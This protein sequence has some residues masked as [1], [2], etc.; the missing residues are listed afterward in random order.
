MLEINSLE[1]NDCCGSSPHEAGE[2]R[3]MPLAGDGNLILCRRCWTRELNWRRD[4][5]R[6]LS[7]EAAY[8]LPAWDH[9]KVYGA[10]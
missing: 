2:V 10:E 5:N 8:D 7:P 9:A 3:V 4:R 6:E 1:N